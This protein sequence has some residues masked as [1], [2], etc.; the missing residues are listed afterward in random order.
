MPGLGRILSCCV[1][2]HLLVQLV[3]ALFPEPHRLFVLLPSTVQSRGMFEMRLCVPEHVDQI[4]QC[5]EHGTILFLLIDM[6]S[7]CLST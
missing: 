6:S 7:G 4:L 2:A 1:L 3:P 5:Q